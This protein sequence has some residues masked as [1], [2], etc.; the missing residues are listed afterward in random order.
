V[1]VARE[2]LGGVGGRPDGVL[3]RVEKIRKINTEK[4]RKKVEKKIKEK[5]EKKDIMD[6]ALSY[7]P[8]T[9]RRSRF[10]KYF[11]KTAPTPP[12]EPL[13]HRSRS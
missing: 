6:I 11:L 2:T 12:E 1:E 3:W 13:H 10:A 9:A 8:Y 7:P 5:K 4:I